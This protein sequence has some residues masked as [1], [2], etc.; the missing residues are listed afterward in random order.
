MAYSYDLADIDYRG[1]SWTIMDYHGLS[2][3]TRE[4]LQLDF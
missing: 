4:A 3:T 1:L 2:W